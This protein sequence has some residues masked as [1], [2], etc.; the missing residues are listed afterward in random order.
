M[1]EVEALL[2]EGR[3]QRAMSPSFSKVPSAEEFAM[4]PDL[5]RR[6]FL[7][8]AGGN[9]LFVLGGGLSLLQPRPARASELTQADAISRISAV[10]SASAIASYSW[11][12]RGEFAGARTACSRAGRLATNANR[13]VSIH[14]SSRVRMKPHPL[15][16]LSR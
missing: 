16:R 13:E 10:A 7:K 1:S 12:N 15:G 5:D 2:S 4:V 6:Q 14:L 8:I 9:G 3:L 11:K